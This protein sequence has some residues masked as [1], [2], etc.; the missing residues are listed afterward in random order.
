MQVETQNLG[1]PKVK[2]IKDPTLDER[3]RQ[4]QNREREKLKLIAQKATQF[5]KNYVKNCRCVTTEM[6]SLR[7]DQQHFILFL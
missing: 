5:C 1:P 6:H 4:D 7:K 3:Q 2:S